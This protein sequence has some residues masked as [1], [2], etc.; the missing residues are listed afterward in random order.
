MRSSV[1][2]NNKGK[3]VLVI[4]ERP[5]QGLDDTKLAAETKYPTNFTQSRKK[6]V[7]ATL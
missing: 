5:G 4:C 2:F 1:H 6:F 7:K 3:Y